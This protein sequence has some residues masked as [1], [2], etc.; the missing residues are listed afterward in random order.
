[1]KLTE[2]TFKEITRDEGRELLLNYHYLKRMPPISAIFGAIHKGRL[3]GVLTFGKPPSNSLCN[4]V[5]GEKWSS[6]V[7]ELNRLYTLDETPKNLESKFIS[8]ALKQLKDR[9]WIIISYADSGMNHSG[10]IYQA[11]NWIYTGMTKGRT[12]IYT[13]NGTHSRHYT[14]EHKN[15]VIR[16]VR[17]VKYR[18]I[19][20]CGDKNFKRQVLKDLKYPIIEEYPKSEPKH[21]KVGDDENRY[22]YNKRTKE[23]ILESDFMASPSSYLNQDD[24][25]RYQEIYL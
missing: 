7:Y 21:Y 18:Y 4:G 3:V 6:Q 12:D 1:M 13:G 15:F 24:F 22:L 5:C 11:T 16:K 2:I 19:Y 8:Y 9:N 14:D 23:I 25:K 20:L 10:Y 17:T